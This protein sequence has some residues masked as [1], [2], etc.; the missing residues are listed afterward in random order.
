MTFTRRRP[1]TFRLGPGQHP[2]KEL[3]WRVPYTV[4]IVDD[5][6]YVRIALR[7]HIERSTDWQVCGQAENGKVAVEQVIALRPDVVI[8]DLQMPVMNGLEAAREINAVAPGTKM[9]MF[10]MHSSAQLEKDARA[11]GIRGV[12]S[13][14]G[15]T[16]EHL[17]AAL[18][19]LDHRP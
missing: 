9:I 4:L 14:T 19:D 8:L 7:D 3:W 16:A 17:L 2:A 6:P 11:A 1:Q 13:K 12:V 5:N 18:R 10:T 15:R